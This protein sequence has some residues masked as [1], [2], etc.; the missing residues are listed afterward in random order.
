V[1]M[2]TRPEPPA[3]GAAGQG[4][5]EMGRE[6]AFTLVAGAVLIFLGLAGSLGTPLVG[7]PDDTSVLVTGPG[8]DIA[9]L[10]MGA[11]YLHIGLALDGRLRAD[12]L[13]LLGAVILVGGLLSLVSA[14]LFGL[15]GAPTSVLDHVAHL[16]LGVIS[17]AVGGVARSAI[18]RQERR[19]S[20]RSRST[21]RR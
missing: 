19:L 2:A 16:A 3:R 7:G 17:I 20:S 5:T 6:R 21:R 12:G 11:L 10:L 8:H 18:V 14:D 15:Y 1:A 4:A 9:H 13:I